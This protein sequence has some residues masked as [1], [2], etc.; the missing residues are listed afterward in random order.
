MIDPERDERPLR[1]VHEPITD[2]YRDRM[3]RREKA[4]QRLATESWPEFFRGY[5]IQIALTLL[6]VALLALLFWL[7]R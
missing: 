7:L 3:K 6:G 4:R 1:D 5:V 2:S